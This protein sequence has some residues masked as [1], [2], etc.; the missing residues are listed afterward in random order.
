MCED[1]QRIAKL[2]EQD[3]QMTF[4]ERLQR[5]RGKAQKSITT[6]NLVDISV[7]ILILVFDVLSSPI[8]I[9]MRVV[10]F[11]IRK[12]VIKYIK[13]FLKWFIHKVLK[14]DNTPLDWKD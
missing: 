8:L 3:T 11:L 5:I 14:I 7:D 9:V 6:D 12:Y 10:R 4:K 13:A 1:F 2:E